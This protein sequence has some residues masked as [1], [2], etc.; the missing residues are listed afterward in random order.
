MSDRFVCSLLQPGPR[1]VSGQH[2]LEAVRARVQPLGLPAALLQDG[3]GDEPVLLQVGPAVVSLV[4]M[5]FPV[6]GE[7]LAR[8]LPTASSR[9]EVKKSAETHR[10][11]VI[12]ACLNQGK[13]NSQAV[14]FA[15]ITTLVAA[16]AQGPLA[17][18]AAYWLSGQ[19]LMPPSALDD[20]ARSL[21]EKELPVANW[22]SLQWFVQPDTDGHDRFGAVSVG[23][24]D[25][26]GREIELL[27][28]AMTNAD[29]AQKIYTTLLY[30][31]VYE[32]KIKDGDTLGE[33][34]ST[35]GILRVR[36]LDR[37]LVHRG[38]V[39]QLQ[40]E[41]VAPAPAQQPAAAHQA[42]GKTQPAFGK[43]G[44]S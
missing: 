44:R 22:V 39:M 16:A 14:L 28:S 32:A 8:A 37:G 20:A 35:S 27:P 33:S 11:H 21:L 18:S 38:P 36:L 7:S 13:D 15:T 4:P 3:S 24:T 42:S 1:A 40:L 23:A 19:I 29:I 5:A 10:A 6:D 41:V 12:V 30:L 9:P 17:A 25:F 43:R 34:E 26:I 31:L 2:L